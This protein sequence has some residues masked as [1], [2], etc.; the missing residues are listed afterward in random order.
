MKLFQ[1]IR[2]NLA[3]FG[4]Y[5]LEP[6]EKNPFNRRNL[7]VLLAFALSTLSAIAFFLFDADS[8]RE[9][10]DSFFVWITVLLTF[11]G[12]LIVILKTDDVFQ[13]IANMEKIIGNRKLTKRF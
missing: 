12:T 7:A 1:A 10:A 13:F 9:S 4:I 5:Q 8:F 11:I 6:S 2:D 3:T